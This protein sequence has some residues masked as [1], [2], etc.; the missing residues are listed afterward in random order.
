MIK[1]RISEI[2]S[3]Q[4]NKRKYYRRGSAKL[5]FVEIYTREITRETIEN[6]IIYVKLS[7][8]KS[9]LSHT[10][11]NSWETIFLNNFI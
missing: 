11:H 9:S 4:R 10:Y 5:N 7:A 2:S 8:C 6:K 3:T 1:G